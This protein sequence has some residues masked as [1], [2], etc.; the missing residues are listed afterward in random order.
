MPPPT[1]RV[2]LHQVGE[3][4]QPVIYDFKLDPEQDHGPEVRNQFVQIALQ[5][6][7]VEGG[8]GCYDVAANVHGQTGKRVMFL[9]GM[10]VPADC[11]GV[12]TNDLRELKYPI[13]ES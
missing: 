12:V 11:R 1:V 5:R 6:R 7:V 4:N 2:R 9:G 13:E 3:G 8:G 10:Y